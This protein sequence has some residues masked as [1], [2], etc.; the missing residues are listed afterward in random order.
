[1]KSS[2]STDPKFLIWLEQIKLRVC[3]RSHDLRPFISIAPYYGKLNALS[4]DEI[5]E[6]G[7]CLYRSPVLITVRVVGNPLL[8]IL[9]SKL[10]VKGERRATY[11]NYY[12]NAQQI[13]VQNL[14][15]S[16]HLATQL[17]RRSVLIYLFIYHQS[18]LPR[19]LP[20]LVLKGKCKC[21]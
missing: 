21:H 1:M 14:V 4:M 8:L 10:L 6:G 11:I 16:S 3:A 20:S 19:Y 5:V 13:P 2:R 12:D 7:G 9:P 15:C 18:S 17:L